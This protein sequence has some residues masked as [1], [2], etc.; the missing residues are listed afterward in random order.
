ML[1]SKINC[2]F[3]VKKCELTR[4]KLQA[5]ILM[6]H[7]SIINIT[8][9]Y[10]CDYSDS[11]VSRF[12]KR[13]KTER[14]VDRK[15]RSSPPRISSNVL[16]FHRHFHAVKIGLKVLPHVQENGMCLHLPFI[17]PEHLTGSSVKLVA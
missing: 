7:K 13:L 14:T 4:G 11:A 12:I 6:P 9:A 2:L 3:P 1:F 10:W 8:I 15:L 5:V 17:V 16:M